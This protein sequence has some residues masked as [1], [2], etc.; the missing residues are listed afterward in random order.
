MWQQIIMGIIGLCA[1]FAI[2]SGAVALV[3]GLGII[4]RY[5]GV[6]KTPEHI[7]WYED[8]CM[9]GT[10]L[11][12][13]AYLW[14]GSIPLGVPGLVLYGVFAGI[15]LGSWIIA[16]GEAVS[17][18]HLENIK[19]W[20]ISRQLWWGHRIPAWYC[21]E[22]GEILVKKGGAPEK[23]PKC[24]CTSLRQDEDTLDTW[25]SLIHI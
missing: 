14:K 2:A 16:L 9:L 12:T 8:C 22:C 17:Y 24:G 7:L 25:L 11:G 19:D 23:C 15:F 21:Q 5:A 18:T 6:T 13:L 1:G 4:P 20:C 3:I 10:I